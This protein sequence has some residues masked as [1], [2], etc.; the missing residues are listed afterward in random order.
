MK[1]MMKMSLLIAA[2]IGLAVT[3]QAQKFGYV[4]SQLILSE[5]SDVKQMNAN[6][7]ALKKQLQKKGQSMLASY[8]QQEQDAMKKK[9]RGELSP[10]QEETLLKQLQGKQ[11]ELLKFEQDMQKQLLE[12]EQKLLEPILTKV[13]TAIQD[14][15][16]ENGYNMIFD[17]S[18]GILLY[19]EEDQDLSAMIKAKLGL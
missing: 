1:N 18:A 3:A 9:E 7:E 16:K 6:L 11:N 2:F 13:N 4:N 17:A 12:K 8:Q 10:V 19:A 15:A 5:M 14:V